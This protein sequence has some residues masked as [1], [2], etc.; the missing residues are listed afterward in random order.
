MKNNYVIA[1]L[2]ISFAFSFSKAHASSLSVNF[3]KD[4]SIPIVNISVAIRSGSSSESRSLEG[5]TSF[6]TDLMLR[7]TK[8]RSRETLEQDLDRIGSSLDAETRLEMTIFRGS[9]LKSELGPYLEILEDVLSNPSFN[10]TELEKLRLEYQ[11][12]FQKQLGNDN[13]IASLAFS[14]ALFGPHPYGN[15]MMGSTKSIAQYSVPTVRTHFE[16]TVTRSNISIFATGDTDVETINR[17]AKKLEAKLPE[18][19]PNA[20]SENPVNNSKRKFIIIDKPDRTQTSIVIGQLGIT[21]LDPRRDAIEVADHI[22]GGSTFSSR[23]MQEIRVKHGWSYGA[24]SNHIYGRRPRAWQIS[25]A[26]ANKDTGP[27]LKRAIEMV[28]ELREKGVTESEFA[29]AKD[30]LIKSDGFNYNTP[31]KRIENTLIEKM[32]NLPDQYMSQFGM[33]LSK[34][35]IDQVQKALAETITPESLVIVLVGSAENIVDSIAEE[36][37]ITKS[38]IQIVPYTKLEEL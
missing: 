2:F 24:Y 23:L 6:T 13:R 15:W 35:N 7:G 31:A 36:L 8:T 34:L 28:G 26:P 37:K 16:N 9:V 14:R 1:L 4:T 12:T 11:G 17:F 25:L 33:R 29:F 21:L 5:I 20:E 30:S 38:S 18:G 27:A 19:K 3:E 22:F 32:L 10:K